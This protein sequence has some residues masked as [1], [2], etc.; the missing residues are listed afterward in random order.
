LGRKQ[1]LEPLPL[2]VGQFMSTYMHAR[3]YSDQTR[4]CKHGL[5]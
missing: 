4:V 3:V 1:R 5:D 2:L